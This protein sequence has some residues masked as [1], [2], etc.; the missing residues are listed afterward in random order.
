[1]NFLLMCDP[2][3]LDGKLFSNHDYEMSHVNHI[4]KLLQ[5]EMVDD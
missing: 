5:K 3:L 1:M 2:V 4:S